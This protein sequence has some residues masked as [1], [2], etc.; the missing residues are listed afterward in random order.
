MLQGLLEEAG[1]PVVLRRMPVSGLPE[2]AY[3]EVPADLDLIVPD[4]RAAEAR[5]LITDY[6]AS[7]KEESSP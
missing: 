3:P 6:L 5:E 4:D 7:L 1:I 2:V